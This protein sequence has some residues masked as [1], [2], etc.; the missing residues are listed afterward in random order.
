MENCSLGEQDINVYSRLRFRGT[1]FNEKG[2][3]RG[4]MHVNSKL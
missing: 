3:F 2:W 4:T 1:F